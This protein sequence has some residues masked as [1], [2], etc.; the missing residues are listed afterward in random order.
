MSAHHAT[1]ALTTVLLAFAVPARAQRS[2]S[3]TDGER[4]VRPSATAVDVQGAA[5]RVD[6]RLDD[7]AWQGATVISGFRQSE[8]NDGA[9]PT[10]RT[11]VRVVYDRD[12]LYVGARL[13]DSEP[14]AI[15]R[16]LAR[17]DAE[18]PSDQFWVAIDSYHDRRT[19]FQ[20]GVNPAGVRVDEISANDD[21]DGDRSWDPVWKVATSV[22]SAGWVAELRIPFSQLRFASG[23]VQTWGINFFRLVFRKSEWSVWSWAPNTEQGFASLFGRLDG[24]R[25]V[26]AP[27]NLEALPYAVAQTDFAQGADP[28]DPFNDGSVQRWS[29]GMDLKYGLSSELTLNATVN[30][31][32][33]QVEVDPAVVNLTAFETFYEERRPFFVEGA[34]MLQ[35]GAGSGGFVFGA[36]QL[37]YSRRIGRAPSRPAVQPDGYVRNPTATSILG[38]AKLSG[39]TGGWSIGLMDALTAPEY[40]R[41]QLADGTRESR[42]VEPRANYG[43]VSLRRE[44]RGGRTGIGAMATGVQR[45]L[46]DSTFSFLRSSAYSGGMDFYHRFAGNQWVLNGSV[47]TTRIAGDPD[48][49]VAAQRSSA[50]YYQRPDQS[51]VSVDSTATNLTG[52]ATSFQVGKVSGNWIYGTDFY[53]YSPGFEVNDAGYQAQADEIFHG[54]RV[55]RRWLDP[56]RTFRNFSITTTWAQTWNFG[57]TND[58]RVAYGRV[59][60]QLLNYWS[61]SVE[62]SYNF[63]TLSDNLTRGGPLMERPSV[64]SSTLTV[65]SDGRKPVSAAVAGQYAH[66]AYGG[67]G[68]VGAAS[69]T[70]RPTNAIQITFS[71][72]YRQT[73]AMSQYVTQ[74]RDTLAT[75]TYGGRYLF[76]ELVQH[77][78]DATMRI[79]AAV[80][81]DLSI[82]WYVQ[83]FASAGDYLGFKELAAPKTFQFLHYGTDGASTLAFDGDQ[84]LYVAD[85]DGPDG[86]AEPIVFRNPD[87]RVRS[88][89]SNL[90]VRWEYIPGSTLFF[91]WNHGRFAFESNPTFHLFD[92][93]ADTFADPMTNTFVVKVN[94]WLSL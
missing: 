6:G 51:Y 10:E 40:A 8:P 85:P 55:T 48:A 61:F 87:F 90:V 28:N 14:D 42:L 53:A 65:S 47:S 71:P 16:R 43:V 31:D 49:M 89:R 20:F 92:Q 76:S 78:I 80:T 59:G 68:A 57:G 27:R 74:R 73:H 77:T 46:S 72:S 13:Y 25:N 37:F 23:D 91:V 12:A 19:A 34:N 18:V 86:A 69:I 39:Q 54:V 7:P 15:T 32:F 9:D 88:L 56:G 33:G 35:F 38:A 41:V 93:L 3:A 63:K 82:Q 50:R 36:P 83:P 44:F 22:D 2:S 4:P 60:G 84:N 5:P 94:Y 70:L 30:P 64:W 45:A 1:W 17:R 21:Q 24:L 66:N 81:P 58:G 62:G 29:A 79:D 11:E 26:P 75:A 52:Y 67:W